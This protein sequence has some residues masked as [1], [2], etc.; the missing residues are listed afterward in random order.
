LSS[1][2]N[3]VEAIR[4]GYVFALASPATFTFGQPSRAYHPHPSLR[5]P[6]HQGNDGMRRLERHDGRPEPDI[7]AQQ[8]PQHVPAVRGPE[9]G[10]T[11]ILS[12]R[13][14]FMMAGGEESKAA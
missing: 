4:Y 13:T 5:W 7:A 2:K 8:R 1:Q 10:A 11:M 9:W 3:A 12:G 6:G 14:T